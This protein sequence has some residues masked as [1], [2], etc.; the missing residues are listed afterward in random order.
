MAFVE[1]LPQAL[2]PS[3]LQD[4]RSCPRRYQLG[5]I[6]RLPQPATY[7]TTKGR[8]VHHVLEHL[9][10][11]EPGERTRERARELTPGA[12]DAVVTED[13]RRDLGEESDLD[14]RLRTDA[15][16]ILDRYFTVEDPREV[17]SEGVEL[18]MQCDLEGTP[19]LGI[20]DRLD[21][22]ENGDLVIVD[23]K[24][25]RVPSRHFDQHTFANAE[26]YA[27]LCREVL[28]ETPS[29][30]R[31]LYVAQ[32]QELE[33]PVRDVVVA[34]RAH[35]AQSAWSAITRYYDDGEFP[36]TP[37]LNACRWCPFRDRCRVDGVAV[38]DS[39]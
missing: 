20:L 13:V 14:R 21:R 9:H 27:V 37:S 1:P 39:L 36:A 3:R 26:L 23:Y 31:L 28:E 30:I 16:Q 15:E 17:V 22:D 11:S 24:T 29:T 33:K 12:F 7:A 25:G 38:P 10:R 8:L 6:E 18:K 34:A 19:L 35:A 32:G 4:F 2:S 5:A